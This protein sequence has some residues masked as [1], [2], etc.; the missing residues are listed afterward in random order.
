[1]LELLESAYYRILLNVSKAALETHA[2][3]CSVE[4]NFS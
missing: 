1:M 3:I 4:I 2:K